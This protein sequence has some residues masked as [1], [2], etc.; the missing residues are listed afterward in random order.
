MLLTVLEIFS[1]LDPRLNLDNDGTVPGCG[2]ILSGH[3]RSIAHFNPRTYS[4]CIQ[5][6]QTQAEIFRIPDFW[7]KNSAQTQ[8]DY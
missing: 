3:V 7:N 8:I 2:L 1:G 6:V 5:G 4:T